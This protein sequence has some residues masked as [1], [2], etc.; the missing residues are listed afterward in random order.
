MSVGEWL[1]RRWV[2]IMAALLAASA[3]VRTAYFA[4]LNGDPAVE[5]HRFVQSDMNYFDAWGRTIAQGD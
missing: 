2:W 4:R 5:L 3:S 1:S